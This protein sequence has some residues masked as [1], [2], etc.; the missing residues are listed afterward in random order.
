VRHTEREPD[1]EA[2]RDAL[3]REIGELRAHLCVALGLLRRE[4]GPEGLEVLTIASDREILA[5]VRQLIVNAAPAEPDGESRWAL[6]DHEI[7]AGRK[8]AAIQRIREEFGGSLH[9]ALDVL[10]GR[11][12][13]L[14][15]L[16]PDQFTQDADTYWDGFYS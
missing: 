16:R 1:V 9:D 14:R 7:F 11:Y 3:R 13:Q 15:R 5:A 4:P 10:T 2:E 8:I 12:E 6:I